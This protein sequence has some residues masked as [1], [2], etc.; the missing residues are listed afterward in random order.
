VIRLDIIGSGQSDERAAAESLRD[1]IRKFWVGIEEDRDSDVRILV[2][3][4][5]P[6]QTVEDIDIVVLAVFAKPPEIMI[7]ARDNGPE[8][9]R[10][11][12]GSFCAV[13][14][15]KTH[16][17]DSVELRGDVLRVKY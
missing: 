17:R 14:E 13:I 7:P 12:L 4:N 8:I 16:Q 1:I 2:D 3:V 6:G 11:L 15:V 5:C 10:F 9:G